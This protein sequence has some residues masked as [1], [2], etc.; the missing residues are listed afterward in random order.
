MAV[1]APGYSGKPLAGAPC[2]HQFATER[3]KL[4]RALAAYRERLPFDALLW[5][6][7][8]KQASKLPTVIAEDLSRK[9]AL[10]LGW[11]M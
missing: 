2:V 7:W 9:L 4:T 5:V 11:W 3:A 1:R 6:S 8:P 10:P